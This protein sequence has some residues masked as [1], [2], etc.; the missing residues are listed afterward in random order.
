MMFLSIS[1]VVGALLTEG[2]QMA[3]SAVLE[4][5]LLEAEREPVSEST[6][7]SRITAARK[8]LWQRCGCT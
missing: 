7:L 5:A 3:T 4:I 8:P 2:A 1:L 6:A